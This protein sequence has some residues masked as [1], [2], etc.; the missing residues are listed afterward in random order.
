[1]RFVLLATSLSCAP[2]ASPSAAQEARPAER[3][4]PMFR[5]DPELTGVATASLPEKLEVRWKFERPNAFQSSAAIADGVVYVGCDD[6][7]LYALSLVDGELRWSY[8]AG[9]IISASPTVLRDTVIV[10]DD[11]GVLHA[12]G[13]ADGAPRWKFKTGGQI[14]SSVNYRDQRLFFGS[15]DGHLYCLNAADGSLVWKYETSD[16]VH[17]TPALADDNVLVAGCDGRLHVVRAGDGGLERTVALGAPC[18]S[19]AARLGPRVFLG[20]HAGIVLAVD[21]RAGR[22]AWSF[23][24]AER[25]FPYLASAAVRD[26]LAVTCG[27]DKRCRAFDAESGA[28]RWEFA[29]GGRIDSSPVISGARVYFGSGDGIVHGLE[30]ATGREVWRF[31]TGSAV[32]ASPA[33]GEGCLVIGTEDGALY[34]LGMSHQSGKAGSGRGE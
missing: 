11:A 31:E 5:G 19:S 23:K 3:G 17:A 27:R 33:I 12:V 24:D 15:Y 30:L 14:I 29:C 2:L 26:R 7:N 8:R 9:E 21:W 18:G 22:V 25:E 16:K 32:S 20:T 10:G 1:M 34:C 28:L 6:G 4:W 13:R